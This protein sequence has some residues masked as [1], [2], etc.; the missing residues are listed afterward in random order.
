MF[1]NQSKSIHHIMKIVKYVL[2]SVIMG[3]CVSWNEPIEK[4]L[5]QSGNNRVEIE[6]VLK[7]YQKDPKSLH[8][9]SAKFLVENMPYFYSLYGFSATK[10][11]QIY[12]KI[13][14]MPKEVRDEIFQ[15]AQEQLSITDAQYFS[16]IK[17]IGHGEQI[18]FQLRII[19]FFMYL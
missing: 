5:T 2:L 17:T 1:F 14:K 12:G 9:L 4:S 19:S 7:H 3:V 13:G 6:K 18:M 16:D 11:F 15:C 8:Y 10:Y